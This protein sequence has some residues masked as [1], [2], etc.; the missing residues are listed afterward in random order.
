MYGYA[1]HSLW[2]QVQAGITID[3]DAGVHSQRS[4]WVHSY[5]LSGSEG[6]SALLG[7]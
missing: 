2:S 5:L 3:E 4:K 1:Q 7:A 6:V